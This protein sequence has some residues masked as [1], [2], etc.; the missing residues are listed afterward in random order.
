VDLLQLGSALCL[1]AVN[2][3]LLLA[4]PVLAAEVVLLGEEIDGCQGSLHYD[5]WGLSAQRKLQA[6]RAAI[7]KKYDTMK[8]T[9]STH[10]QRDCNDQYGGGL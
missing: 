3:C 5:F 6:R 1:Q 8:N 9:K 2:A 4:F 7:E 10:L